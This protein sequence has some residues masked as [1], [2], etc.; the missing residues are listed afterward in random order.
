M[1]SLTGVPK[2]WIRGWKCS[3]RRRRELVTIFL[4]STS[5]YVMCRLPSDT[6]TPN[7]F[8]IE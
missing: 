1:F 2:D 3:W 8:V 5:G 4:G 6:F 7:R